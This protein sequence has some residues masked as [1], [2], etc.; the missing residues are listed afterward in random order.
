M[1]SRE[2]K[3]IAHNLYKNSVGVIYYHYMKINR[4]D[5]EIISD[6][7]PAIVRKFGCREEDM[8]KHYLNERGWLTK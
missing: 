3:E 5:L 6:V 7:D 8:K 4:N 1:K 2:Q